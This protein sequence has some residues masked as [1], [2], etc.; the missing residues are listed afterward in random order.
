MIKILNVESKISFDDYTLKIK[1]I[2]VTNLW[3]I[4][5]NKDK[6]PRI[7]NGLFKKF[8]LIKAFIKILGKL[9]KLKL[10]NIL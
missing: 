6:F 4:Y 10:N 7:K 9:F 5:L 3:I 8:S 2:N 1:N